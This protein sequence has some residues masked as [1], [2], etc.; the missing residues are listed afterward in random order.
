MRLAV[1]CIGRRL[2]YLVERAVP[3]LRAIAL[4]IAAVVQVVPAARA[5]S[6]QEGLGIYH[7]GSAYTVSGR[8][9][10][11][12]GAQQVLDLGATVISVAM[13]PKYNSSDYP[14]ESF[15][16]AISS[17]SELAQTP[18]FRQL[19]RMPFKTYI[20]MS[21]SFSTWSTWAN[22]HPHGTFT[23]TMASQEAAELHD[24]AKHLL[25]TYQGTGKTFIIKNWEGDWFIDENYD[26][27][28][29]PSSDQIQNAIAWFNARHAG[30]VQA[31]AEATGVTG[32]EV[33]N[34]VEFDFV[35]RV[36]RGVPS[37]LNS[38]VPY[39]Q[40]D[41]IS[42]GC[43]DMALA[44]SPGAAS[45]TLLRQALLDDIAYIRAFPGVGSRPLFIGEYGFPEEHFPDAGIRTGIAAQAFLDAGLP[46]A[47][48][49]V[50]EGGNGLALVRPDGTH[51]AA[52]D[53][54][55]RMLVGGGDVNRQGLWWAAPP[56][57]ESGWGV[58]F[59]HQ[60]DVI[61]A[62][63]FTYDA[64]GKGWWLSMTAPK[65]APATYGGTL[66][67]TT[68][69]AFSAKPFDPTRVRATA[70]GTGLLSFSDA[71]SGTFSS[72]VNYVVQSKR[73]TRQVFGPLPDC[74][75]ASESLAA[76][77]NYQ[78]L[79]WAAPAGSESGWG[80]NLTQQGNVI[81]A[82]WFTY[83]GDS[84]PMWLVVTANKTAGDT[85]SGTLYRTTGPAFAAMP[86]DPAKVVA[87]AVGIATF[88]FTDG[89]TATFAYSVNDV[90]QLK[91]IVREVFRLPGTVCH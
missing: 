10:L 55:H 56:G 44:S 5:T 14:G 61:F 29:V 75:T 91:T 76:A 77:T 40:S 66:Y 4:V 52:W 89:N 1:S 90:S 47:I 45:T 43:Y 17:L 83:D 24:L 64:T 46:Y 59:A 38:V 26:P 18:D 2:G 37:M 49:W 51:S 28:Y 16:G 71:N 34:A 11:L 79:W 20:L 39:V 42:C 81:F 69:P 33:L 23:S 13:T 25:Q 58:N 3:R 50:I 70:V 48:N 62:T 84:T 27:T 6:A 36:K 41:L 88:A 8:P 67:A 32:V 72:V 65:I 57:S 78:D 80:I 60:A 85:F 74:G 9:S 87:T 35:Q 31:R 21:L 63:W 15:G 12:D 82:T 86:F 7:W 19:F 30:V 54:L 73:I 22:I 53:V 68:G